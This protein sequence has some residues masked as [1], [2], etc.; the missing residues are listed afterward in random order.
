M[1]KKI[2]CLLAAALLVAGL[3]GCGEKETAP[4]SY[5]APAALTDGEKELLEL[6]DVAPGHL[7]EYQ[8]G[9]TVKGMDFHVYRLTEGKWIPLT[10]DVGGVSDFLEEGASG[11]MAVLFDTIPGG[12][13][14]A[15]ESARFVGGAVEE[16]PDG[17]SVALVSLGEKK[18]I[19]EGTEVPMV[20]QIFG[21]NAI[22][23]H[24]VED[25]DHPEELAEKNYKAVYAVTVTFEG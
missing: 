12:V 17:G 7:F 22:G 18:P 11:R 16:A 24:G 9:E 19:Q 21:E 20:L 14:I 13:E 10:A 1:K 3:A 6:L 8:L 5:I 25:F 4:E 15:V 2:S 23:T